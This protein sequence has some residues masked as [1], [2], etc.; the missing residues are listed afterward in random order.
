[1]GL[2]I[3]LAFIVLVFW[4]IHKLRSRFIDPETKRNQAII[5]RY[6][7]IGV[8]LFALLLIWA[9]FTQPR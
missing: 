9:A 1:M 6:V 4:V 7:L 5:G 2:V 3:A 8:G